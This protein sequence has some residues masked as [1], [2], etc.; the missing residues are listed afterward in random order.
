MKSINILSEV[1]SRLTDIEASIGECLEDIYSLTEENLWE[2]TYTVKKGKIVD[3]LINKVE[4]D[5]KKAQK[6][7]KPLKKADKKFDKKIA[8][9]S[10]VLKKDKKMKGK[11]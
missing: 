4:K 5:V 10:K 3:K 2:D 1:Y 8:S 9:A 7:I 11:K 6:D